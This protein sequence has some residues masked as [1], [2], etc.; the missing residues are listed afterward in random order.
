MGS[1][2]MNGALY[3]L[4]YNLVNDF[5]PIAL[6]TVQPYMVVARKTMPGDDLK[7]LIAWLRANPGKASAGTQG[8]GGSS[9][10]GG[11]FFHADSSSQRIES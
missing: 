11:V 6:V 10:I 8:A 9:Q 4:P 5:E 7:G 2:V 3:S 1:F